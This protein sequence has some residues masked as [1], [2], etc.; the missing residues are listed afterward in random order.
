MN[1]IL[2]I[3]DK[4]KGSL[5]A[6]EV[7]SI[8]ASQFQR[9]IPNIITCELP[10]ADGGDGT[11]DAVSD[12]GH[13]TLYIQ[14]IDAL[15]RDIEV[16]VLRIGDKVLCEMAKSTGLWSLSHKERNPR[17]TSSYGFGVVIKEVARLGFRNI[18]LGIGGSATNDA[19]TGMLS[20]L[21]YRFL[22]KDGQPIG[23][24]D[25]LGDAKNMFVDVTNESGLPLGFMTGACLE[26]IVAIDNSGVPDYLKGLNIE[27][28]CDVNNPL[29]GIYGASHV[30]GPQKGA[31]PKDVEFLEAGVIHFAQVCK[32]FFGKD[33][34]ELTGAGA[35]GGMGF[36]LALFLDAKLLSGWRVI[37]DFLNVDKQIEEATL[38]ITGE[39]RVDGQ[40]LSGKLLDGVIEVTARHRKRLWVI[41][42][43]NL[44][45]D[46]ELEM[47]GVEKL[48]S[49]SQLQPSKKKAI[50]D[51]HR[52]LEKIA[53]EA[54]TF[55]KPTASN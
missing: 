4:F 33:F 50:A 53:L 41:C 34:S 48:F 8:I 23:Y 17:F 11:L 31:S 35:A 27:V 38:V 36:A 32:E 19:G 39:G 2:I 7:A 14:T 6:R 24:E 51:A 45:T 43:D 21:G 10:L 28:A 15:G 25:R 18:L 30:Y 16:P 44:L 5:T 46:R 55:F 52:Y 1:K 49:I 20:A 29:I 13:E 40:S 3:V 26:K 22:D 42:G 37:F 54:A 9:Q 12:F 47:V